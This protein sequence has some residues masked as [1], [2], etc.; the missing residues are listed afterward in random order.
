DRMHLPHR[1]ALTFA[2]LA[3]A[4]EALAQDAAPPPVTPAVEP[5]PAMKQ[6]I[7]YV[8]RPLTLPAMTLSPQLDAAIARA[9]F[10]GRA[11][12]AFQM[13]VAGSFGITDD[14]MVE[15]R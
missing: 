14:L 3:A 7:A 5:E 8:E 15:A 1:L 10:G 2:L 4:T 12:T 9:D 13:E 11:S 6:P